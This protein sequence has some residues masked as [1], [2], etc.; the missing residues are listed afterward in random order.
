MPQEPT[1]PQMSNESDLL[2]CCSYCG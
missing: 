2:H 1:E